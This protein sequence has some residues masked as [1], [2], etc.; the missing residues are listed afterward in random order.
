MPMADLRSLCE[1]VGWSDVR[2]YIQS[3][4]VI[5]RTDRTPA[6][7]EEELE[8]AIVRQFGFA[9]PVLV[10]A[11]AEWPGYIR[12]NPFPDASQTDPNLVLL[13]LSKK[14]PAREAAVRLQERAAAGERIAHVENALWIHFPNGSGRSK[15]SPALLDRLVESPVTTRNWRTVLKLE[16]LSRE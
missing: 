14:L 6:E 13:A 15:L 1:G 4:N 8:Q 10:R 2:T 16:E 3:G 11:A 7:L 5:F 9:V 12:A